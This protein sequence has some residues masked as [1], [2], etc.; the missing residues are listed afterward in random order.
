MPGELMVR[1]Q[2]L[3]EQHKLRVRTASRVPMCGCWFVWLVNWW[4]RKAESED[5][6]WSLAVTSS[7]VLLPL[8][9]GIW[10]GWKDVGVCVDCSQKALRG[11]MCS[12]EFTEIDFVISQ[13]PERRS[14]LNL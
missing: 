2:H 6:G 7:V 14:C 4:W 13:K 12:R 11:G 1:K 9:V 3:E 8:Q 10:E 5:Q